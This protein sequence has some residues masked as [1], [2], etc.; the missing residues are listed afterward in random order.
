MKS[1]GEKGEL[2]FVNTNSGRLG[3]NLKKFAAMFV[4]KYLLDS[5]SNENAFITDWIFSKLSLIAIPNGN[6]SNLKYLSLL[7]TKSKVFKVSKEIFS[8]SQTNSSKELLSL[9]SMSY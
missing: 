7:M 1:N 9:Y 2:L 6:T 3:K 4:V 8:I 5:P